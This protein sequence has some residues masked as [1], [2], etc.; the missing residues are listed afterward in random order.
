MIKPNVNVKLQKANISLN[1]CK[2]SC[3]KVLKRDFCRLAV[4]EQFTINKYCTCMQV[5]L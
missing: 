3:F 1:K 4:S 2:F 5:I